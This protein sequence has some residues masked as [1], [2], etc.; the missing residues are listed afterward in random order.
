MKMGLATGIRVFSRNWNQISSNPFLH[1]RSSRL[2]VVKK[3]SAVVHGSNVDAL[4]AKKNPLPK[5]VRFDKTFRHV[6]ATFHKP[7]GAGGG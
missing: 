3:S 2:S 5:R 1:L 4:P 6:S 7:P